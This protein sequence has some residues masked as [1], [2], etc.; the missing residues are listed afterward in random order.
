MKIKSTL[1]RITF[2]LLLILSLS[3]AAYA[4]QNANVTAKPLLAK[5]IKISKNLIKQPAP[6]AV[7]NDDF[8]ATLDQVKQTLV[9]W[10]YIDGSAA[11]QQKKC[12]EKSY[13]AADQQAA[14]CLGSDTVDVCSQKLYHHCM[15]TGAYHT[16]YM[17]TLN[18]MKDAVDNLI[19]KSTLYRKGLDEAEKKYQ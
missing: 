5:E 13:N 7:S 6:P 1:F 8:K 12:A 11:W 3:C 18:K 9:S 19:K 17:S 2:S 15:Q 4:A 14:G 16:T 10:D